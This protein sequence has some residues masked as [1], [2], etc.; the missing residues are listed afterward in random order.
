VRHLAGVV[1]G[2][3]LV[4]LLILS[5]VSYEGVQ[6]METPEFCGLVC[7]SVMAPE[8]TSYVNSPHARVDCVECHIGP[9]APWFV[10]SKLSGVGQVLAVTFNTYEHPIP[11]PVANLRPSQDTCEQCHWPERFTGDRIRVIPKFADDEANTATKT[12]LL[13]HIG[14]G[15]MSAA[16]IHSW[17]IDP[18]KQTTYFARDY[19]RQDIPVVRVTRTDGTETEYVAAGAEGET[20]STEGLTPRRMDCI[21]CHNRPTHIFQVPDRA[22]NQAMADGRISPTLPYIKKVG[23]EALTEATGEEGDL[24]RIAEKVTTFYRENYA[25]RAAE[26]DPL[27]AQAVE[28]MQAIYKRNVFPQMDVTWGTYRSN[29]GH[30]VGEDGALGCFRCHDDSHTNKEGEVIRQDC[31]ICHT[32]LAMDEENPEIL[33]QLGLAQPAPVAEPPAEEPTPEE[34]AAAETTGTETLPAEPAPTEPAAEAA[35][36]PAAP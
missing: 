13:M 21:D 2:L 27:V 20:V 11:T 31:G 33:V 36:T 14:G 24:E 30:P 28:A 35:E 22:M 4:N 23:T 17:H 3:T 10:R 26:L 19:E 16:G 6:Y 15:E 1:S 8:H 9:G 5:T 29:L 34:P 12:V 7:H 18:D 25:D 32:M